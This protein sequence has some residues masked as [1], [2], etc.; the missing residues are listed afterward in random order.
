MNVNKT[1]IILIDPQNDFL[2]EE[3]KLYSAVEPALAKN[4]VI[5]KLNYL[6]S[7][8]HKANMTVIHIPI[9][10]DKE[11]LEKGEELYGIMAPVA[12]AGGFIRGTKGAAIADVLDK[13]DTDIVIEKNHICA[14]EE[15]N[16]EQFLNKKGITTVILCGLLTDV[17]VEAT[18]RIA[19]D[20]G[21]E[22][23]TVTDATAT[24]GIEKQEST[25]E[26]NFPLFSKP[27]STDAALT[28]MSGA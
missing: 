23:F 7:A 21:F 15:T 28:M 10:F 5:K 19:Y 6:L 8:S 4:E 26:N 27:I 24:L 18:M 16:L 3:G 20:K 11:S 14:F 25:I 12:E 2:S 22:V 1:A 9:V 17:C 13:A